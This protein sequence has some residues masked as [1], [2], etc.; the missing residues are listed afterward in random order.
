MERWS[1]SPFWPTYIGEKGRT[2]GK[3]YGINARYYWE[4]PWGTHWELEWNMLGTK[5]KISPHTQNLKEKKI[6]WH[7]ECLL[8]LPIGYTRFL[9][10][11]TI[12]HHFWLG[13]IP[14]L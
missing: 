7:V 3:T 4:H 9:F 10:S 11:K 12:R 6:I 2:L 13:L 5:E 14:P 1:A 8:S